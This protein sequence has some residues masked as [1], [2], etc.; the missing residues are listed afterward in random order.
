MPEM[1]AVYSSHVDEIGYDPEKSEL[2]VKYR[3]G[4]TH[5]YEGVPSETA[6]IVMSA[7][8]I[9]KALHAEVRSKFKSRPL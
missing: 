3:T 4:Q 6:S 2:H 7:P 9:G 8:S 5:V 1:R